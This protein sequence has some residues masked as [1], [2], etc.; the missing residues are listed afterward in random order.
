MTVAKQETAVKPKSFA[1]HCGVPCIP[2]MHEPHC[3]LYCLEC[4]GSF[5]MFGTASASTTPELQ[6]KWEEVQQEWNENVGGK[7][8]VPRSLRDGCQQCEETKA[9]DH[10]SHATDEEKELDR[11]ARHWMNVRANIPEPG[12]V[13]VSA[14]KKSGRRWLVRY[15]SPG[16]FGR[17]DEWVMEPLGTGRG[18]FL[19][20][21]GETI[22]GV[23][24]IS[25]LPRVLAD[26]KKWTRVE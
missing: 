26:R 7:L 19:N 10:P 5:G 2:T 16:A 6:K 17:A 12:A 3:E 8:L 22:G 9:F 25:R 1:I 24:P 15:L 20:E 13:Y 18:G 4:G 11:Q 21:D 23:H 14:T